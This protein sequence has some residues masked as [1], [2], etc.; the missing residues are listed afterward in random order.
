MVVV[1]GLAQIAVQLL[2]VWSM[3]WSRFVDSIFWSSQLVYLPMAS[4]RA[5]YP[6]NLFGDKLKLIWLQKFGENRVE[7]EDAKN[8]FESGGLESTGINFV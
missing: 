4:C 3:L 8:L 2:A 5:F 6:L 7:N 1:K